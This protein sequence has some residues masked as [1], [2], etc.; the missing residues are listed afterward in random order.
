LFKEIG[1]LGDTIQ[2]ARVAYGLG[3]REL[4]RR[5]GVSPAQISRIESGEVAK[6][7]VDT[8]VSIARGL[9]RNP[10]PLLIASGHIPHE[11]ARQILSEMFRPRRGKTYNPTTDSEL[12]E[13]WLALGEK[14]GVEKARRLLANHDSGDRD[15]R[16]LA[17]EVFFTT[18]T[19][20]TLW[21]E[22]F[23]E[24]LAH[25]SDDDELRRLAAFWQAL[26][27]E[28]RAK[29]LEYAA[30]QTELAHRAAGTAQRAG[31]KGVDHRAGR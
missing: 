10:A 7:S 13:E 17:A 19:A 18:E 4:G 22:S 2:R 29:V 14:S 25:Q 28:R 27:S 31:R 21:R 5:S 23:I 1:M 24:T 12:V 9:D 6:P 20:E 26:P 8:L 16:K 11:E 15:L 3:V 30:E